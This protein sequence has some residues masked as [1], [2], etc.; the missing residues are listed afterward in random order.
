MHIHRIITNSDKEGR[1]ACSLRHFPFLLTPK[2]AEGEEKSQLQQQTMA[3]LSHLGQNAKGCALQQTRSDL[4]YAACGVQT[5]E[6]ASRIGVS[7]IYFNL[8]KTRRYS[9][10]LGT[11]TAKQCVCV[12]KSCSKTWKWRNRGDHKLKVTKRL[13]KTF[14][15][16]APS[17]TKRSAISSSS[18]W[19]LKP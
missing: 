15:S 7:F 17:F 2:G 8:A 11:V 19:L 18:P 6:N 1:T 12:W 5:H 13:M 9:W 3:V 10:G 14:S 16:K 4:L